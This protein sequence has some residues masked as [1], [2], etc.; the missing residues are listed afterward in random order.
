MNK[1]TCNVEVINIH[2]VT[3]CLILSFVASFED[4]S[5]IFRTRSVTLCK[6]DLDINDMSDSATGVRVHIIVI[7]KKFL[8][9]CSVKKPGSS[10]SVTSLPVLTSIISSDFHSWED[11]ILLSIPLSVN[12][13]NKRLKQASMFFDAAHSKSSVRRTRPILVST[14]PHNSGRIWMNHEAVNPIACLPHLP[15]PI[16]NGSE[17][18]SEKDFPHESMRFTKLEIVLI[19]FA[20]GS[21]ASWTLVLSVCSNVSTSWGSNFGQASTF[22]IETDFSML[23]EWQSISLSSVDTEMIWWMMCAKQKICVRRFS[24]DVNQETRPPSFA[25]ETPT[26]RTGSS[27]CRMSTVFVIFYHDICR[28]QYPRSFR[29]A[30]VR[31]I[32][33]SFFSWT[34]ERPMSPAE[35]FLR[36][37]SPL[38]NSKSIHCNV[39][40][41][42]NWCR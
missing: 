37:F 35:I 39:L 13:M 2:H 25:Q 20:V 24:A 26:Q 3:E 22:P 19:T 30:I 34:E 31:S 16:V 29:F 28:S 10:C 6:K 27:E 7:N 11:K 23:G 1:D 38:Q 12:L 9:V 42:S 8:S 17:L 36:K 14:D 41:L 40:S 21:P 5:W 33:I 15:N 4:W 32:P 18:L